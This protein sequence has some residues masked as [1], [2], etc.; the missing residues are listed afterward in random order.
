VISR[1]TPTLSAA[2]I[3]LWAPSFP[4]ADRVC[5]EDPVGSGSFHSPPLAL[6]GPDSTKDHLK[7]GCAQLPG[8]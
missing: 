4:V 8:P 7:A 1:P 6:L 3:S 2:A 5:Q